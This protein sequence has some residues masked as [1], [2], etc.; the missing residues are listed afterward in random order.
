MTFKS[1]HPHQYAFNKYLFWLQVTITYFVADARKQGERYV[2]ETVR[3]KRVDDIE[4]TVY[5]DN[6]TAV[7]YENIYEL[8]N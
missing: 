7:K 2:T 4:Q 1:L 6:N 3:V 5:L 8:R